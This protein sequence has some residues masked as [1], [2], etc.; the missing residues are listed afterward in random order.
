MSNNNSYEA[1]RQNFQ[2]FKVLVWLLVL[3]NKLLLIWTN[4]ILMAP[5]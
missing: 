2:I 1:Y 4:L 3:L 5:G